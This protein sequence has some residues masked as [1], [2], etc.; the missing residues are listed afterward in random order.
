MV[1]F[2]RT[3][4][5][6]AAGPKGQAFEASHEEVQVSSGAPR[7]PGDAHLAV[8]MRNHWR[9]LRQSIDSMS[10]ETFY[11]QYVTNIHQAEGV[12][13]SG[14]HYPLLLKILL[15]LCPVHTLSVCVCFFLVCCFVRRSLNWSP[16]KEVIARV[17][18]LHLFVMKYRWVRSMFTIF[19]SPCPLWRSISTV[20]R[21]FWYEGTSTVDID[22][23]FLW[24]ESI[25][26]VNFDQFL[27]EIDGRSNIDRIFK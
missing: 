11:R 27:G 20:D 9:R 2:F 26:T 13:E 16:W 14:I 5:E 18:H 4:R 19:L 10:G 7:R 15:T 1:L 8:S 25:S 3:S 22:R 12:K 17:N 23:F 6:N 21:F 24:Y